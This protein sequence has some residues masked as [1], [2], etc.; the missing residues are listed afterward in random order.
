MP[1]WCS[2]NDTSAR[3]DSV[4]LS[5]ADAT[6]DLPFFEHAELINDTFACSCQIDL[7]C[8]VCRTEQLSAFVDVDACFMFQFEQSSLHHQTLKILKTSQ[9]PSEE[10]T[11]G[12]SPERT[13]PARSQLSREG[14]RGTIGRS[15]SQCRL[16][17]EA[18]VPLISRKGDHGQLEHGHA[19][20][21]EF[22]FRE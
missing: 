9:P 15:M 17:K 1:S 18:V 2:V 3:D 13:L 6:E 4:D 22:R 20:E 21:S 14:A 16:K 11:Y 8:K 10:E 19:R 12:S 7:L 5:V